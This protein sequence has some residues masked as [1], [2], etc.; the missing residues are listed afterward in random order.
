VYGWVAAGLNPFPLILLAPLAAAAAT[1]LGEELIVPRLARRYSLYGV[2]VH[3][4]W[5]PRIPETG[6]SAILAGI[7][8]S[9]AVL[10]PAR[11]VEAAAIGLSAAW[12]WLLGFLDDRY[13]LDPV[14]KPLL[15]SGA[16]IP[17]L[18]LGCCWR[19][20][21]P[22][23]GWVRLSIVYPFLLVPGMAVASNMFNMVDCLNGM[24]A[25]AGVAVGLSLLLAEAILAV[26][27]GAVDPVLAAGLAGLVA[28][29]A[30]HLYYNWY[31]ARVFNGDSGSLLV[32]GVLLAYAVYMHLEYVFLVASLPLILNGF[33]IVSSIRGLKERREIP[34]PTMVT[35]EGLIAARRDRGAPITLIRLLT[36]GRAL[37]ED[38]VVKA[39]IIV[40]C[41]SSLLAVSSALLLPH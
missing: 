16:A 26:L 11:P 40:L 18:A 29:L 24:M 41:F 20:R 21:L 17:L 37:R 3:K 35:G 34:R 31:P 5:R 32:G 28:V 4:P 27:G 1:W 38:E 14:S 9:L 19:T 39:F 10:A 23:L 6:G 12:L 15:S 33:T 25:S 36:L 22:F 30:L 13:R 8:A 2:D 7:L